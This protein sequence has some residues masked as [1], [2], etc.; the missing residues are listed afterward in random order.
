MRTTLKA[1]LKVTKA[2]PT[3]QDILSGAFSSIIE[4]NIVPTEEKVA[5]KVFKVEAAETERLMPKVEEIKDT[6]EV[7]TKFDHANIVQCKGIAFLPDR[8]MPVLL[9]EIIMESIQSYIK[10]HH[11]LSLE[12]QVKILQ[13]TASGLNYLHT[14]KPIF[15]HG[16]LTAE[17]VLLD[18]DTL[19]AKIGGFNLDPMPQTSD[20]MEYV[21]PAEDSTRPLTD[22]SFD[23]FSFGHLALVTLLQEEVKPLLPSQYVKD[24][25]PV[26][27]HEVERRKIFIDKAKQLV[28]DNG[29][30]GMIKK[31]L[32]NVPSKRPKIE[33]IIKTLQETS[34]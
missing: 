15:I 30:F 2:I 8:I 18:V 23:V 27:R 6:V 29:L 26:I 12:H 28:G 3:G 5:G 10:G 13:G 24:N 25:E 11:N 7:I 31:C 22:P 19:H 33:E 20:P 21:S 16:H 1:S 14:L 32:E 9:M 4:L 17:N 34:K